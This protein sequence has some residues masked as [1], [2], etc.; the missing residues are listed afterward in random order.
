MR[1]FTSVPLF[2]SLPAVMAQA[3][4]AGW[5]NEKEDGTLEIPK[6]ASKAT[7]KDFKE[8]YF[9]LQSRVVNG[10]KEYRFACYH[11]KGSLKKDPEYAILLASSCVT[12][13]PVPKAKVTEFVLFQN[14]AKAEPRVVRGKVD[15]VAAWT[16]DLSNRMRE[17]FFGITAQR[18]AKFQFFQ[19]M[20]N[21]SVKDIFT[22][23]SQNLPPLSE[24]VVSA[25]VCMRL[26]CMYVRSY[27]ASMRVC[28]YTWLTPPFVSV[29]ARRLAQLMR[30][31]AMMF[32]Y[33]NGRLNANQP[34]RHIA[35]VLRRVFFSW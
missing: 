5:Q 21:R 2:C 31:G 14:E 12:V 1:P 9:A 25:S 34:G 33:H 15:N 26:I 29:S 24:Y 20:G 10:V 18:L 8:R 30:K 19:Q 6:T 32:R 16:L 11:D 35:L 27:S 17:T 28:A 4:A 23:F 22:A 13:P 3:A 7:L